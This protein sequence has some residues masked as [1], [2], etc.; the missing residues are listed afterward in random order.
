MSLGEL[1]RRRPSGKATGCF[2]RFDSR[3]QAGCFFF[4]RNCSRA[5]HLSLA[6]RALISVD[7]PPPTR[8]TLLSS[9]RKH[10]SNL[11]VL[12][13]SFVA[14]AL[15]SCVTNPIWVVKTRMQQNVESFSGLRHALLTIARNEGIRGLYSGIIPAIVGARCVPGCPRRRGVRGR[16]SCVRERETERERPTST[17]TD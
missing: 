8:F 13:S 11:S 2:R 3:K 17:D 5:G 4:G 14:G 15:T 12:S 16:T 10:P 7:P 6:L 9:R 1:H